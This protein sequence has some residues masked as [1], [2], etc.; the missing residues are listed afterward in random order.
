MAVSC[1]GRAAARRTRSWPIRWRSSS[2]IS[3]ARREG[4]LVARERFVGPGGGGMAPAPHGVLPASCSGLNSLPDVPPVGPNV[5]AS[6]HLALAPYDV[7][8]AHEEYGISRRGRQEP[9]SP[10]IVSS[11]RASREEGERNSDDHADPTR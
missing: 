7:D 8:L 5:L 4:S 1:N 3:R 2:S 9:R 6:N 10:W 11:R